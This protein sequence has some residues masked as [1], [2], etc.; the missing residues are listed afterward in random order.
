MTPDFTVLGWA[1]FWGLLGQSIRVGLGLRKWAMD[2]ARTDPFNWRL[3][4]TSLLFGGISGVVASLAPGA[5]PLAVTA[6][7][8]AGADTIEGT[9]ARFLPAGGA[10][11]TNSAFLALILLVPLAL[12][13]PQPAMAQTSPGFECHHAAA[14]LDELIGPNREGVFTADFTGPEIDRLRAA[15]AA[16]IGH[17][18]PA[19]SAIRLV[20]VPAHDFARFFLYGLDDCFAWAASSTIDG[21]VGILVRAGVKLP[22]FVPPL[23]P[24]AGPAI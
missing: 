10:S 4:A 5:T 23:K 14:L 15:L 8:F 9:F 13:A 17:P 22:S 2:P 21:T 3:T 16:D 12:F 1:F 7:G 11:S 18:L 6:L 24:P 20:M 19:A